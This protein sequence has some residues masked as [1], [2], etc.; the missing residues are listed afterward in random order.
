MVGKDDRF[1]WG[2]GRGERFNS[3]GG[4]ISRESTFKGLRL[5]H[6]VNGPIRLRGDAKWRTLDASD[7]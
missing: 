1:G 5:C 6:R 4:L 7:G 3:E 2:E